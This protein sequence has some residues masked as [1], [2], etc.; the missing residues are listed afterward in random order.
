MKIQVINTH[1]PRLEAV[2]PKGH[3]I[4]TKSPVTLLVGENNTGKTA[5]LKLLYSSLVNG[6]YFD[7][8]RISR[9]FKE[10]KDG[11]TFHLY[12]AEHGDEREDDKI[13]KFLSGY[14]G[15]ITKKGLEEYLKQSNDNNR[16]VF[17]RLEN[18]NLLF[19][20]CDFVPIELVNSIESYNYDSTYKNPH[21]F[22]LEEDF[23]QVTPGLDSR[24]SFDEILKRIQNFYEQRFPLVELKFSTYFF[25]SRKEKHQDSIE[26]RLGEPEY[27]DGQ[28]WVCYPIIIS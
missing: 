3:D 25:D 20:F 12:R 15:E 1:E 23:Y 11:G 18:G 17:F 21:I 28:T 24:R 27:K 14:N 2:L 22:S 5:F 19:P 9:L 26:K 8:Q 13:R 7:Y 10:I 6:H 4:V 16:F